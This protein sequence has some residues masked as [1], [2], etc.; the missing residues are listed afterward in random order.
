[1]G[2][3]DEVSGLSTELRGEQ[4]IGKAGAGKCLQMVKSPFSRRNMPAV[5]DSGPGAKHQ[6]EQSGRWEQGRW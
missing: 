3:R 6:E 4:R 5:Q 1:M 2:L